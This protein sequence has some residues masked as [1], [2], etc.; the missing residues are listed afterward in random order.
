M[1]VC[2]WGGTATPACL[3]HG[4]PHRHDLVWEP[5]GL[6]QVF[7]VPPSRAEGAVHSG[8]GFRG[9]RIQTA[10]Q[11]LEPPVLINCP[12]HLTIEIRTKKVIKAVVQLYKTTKTAVDKTK[13]K[14]QHSS[15]SEGMDKY[16][17]FYLLCV[18]RMECCPF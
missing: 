5:W 15:G 2:V 12:G 9:N 17:S 7:Y 14:T 18:S 8:E 4:V 3:M 10:G 6:S 13:S 1:G 16:N 11:S